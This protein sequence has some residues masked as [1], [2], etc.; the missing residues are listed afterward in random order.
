MTSTSALRAQIQ[1]ALAPRV[2]MEF[3]V[4]P[5]ETPELAASGLAELD[6][7]LGGGLPRGN[8]TEVCGPESSGKTSLVLSL[9]SQLTQQQEVCA[10]VDVCDAFDPESLAAVGGDLKRLLWIRCGGA[11]RGSKI[12]PAQSVTEEAPPRTAAKLKTV[13]TPVRVHGMS[14]GQGRHP[15][16]EVKGLEVAMGF[17]LQDEKHIATSYRQIRVASPKAYEPVESQVVARCAGEQVSPDRAAPRRVDYFLS[18]AVSYEAKPFA[19]KEPQK[20]MATGTWERPWNRLEQALKTTD[21]L[22]HSGG[23][24][25]VVLDLGEVDWM[26]ARRIPLTTW[27]RLKRAVENTPTMLVVLGKQACAGTSA[28]L[29]LQCLRLGEDWAQAAVDANPRAVVLDGLGV[30]VEVVRD[31]MQPAGMKHGKPPRSA[32]TASWNTRT[33]WMG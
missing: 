2:A 4:R 10:L 20:H 18:Q 7:L 16:Q 29:V 17:L 24:G 9:L 33:F 21:L 31:R 6:S 32:N 1:A 27:F 5:R 12:E 19:A 26:D 22:L 8:L 25:A 11:A 3:A 14:C 30:Q 13:P 28:S 23:F 15:R